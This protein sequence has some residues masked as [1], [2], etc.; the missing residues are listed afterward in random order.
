MNEAFIADERLAAVDRALPQGDRVFK[1]LRAETGADALFVSDETY[2]RYVASFLTEGG[3]ALV[4]ETGVKLFTDARYIEAA[5]KI[6]TPL[7]VCV[8]TLSKEN[9]PEAYLSRYKKVGVPF[10]EI[11][12][13]EFL[14]LQK[15]GAQFVDASAAIR[16]CA[17]VKTKEE[18]AMI[19][20]ACDF[21]EEGLLRSLPQIREG[22]SERDLAAVL[23]NEMRSLGADGTSFDTIVAF[24]AG[25]AV[26]HHE[27]DDTKLRYGDPVLIDFGCRVGGYCSD[28]TRTFLFGDDGKHEAFKKSYRCVLGAHKEALSRIQEGMTGG[29]ADAIARD[30]LS[31]CG[32]GGYFTHSLG[33]GIGLKVHEFPSLRPGNNEPLKNGMVFSDEPGVYIAGEFG[34]RIEDTVAMIDGKACTL[35][36]KVG[37]ELIVL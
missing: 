37:K 32:Y 4:D 30:Y 8:Q 10:S 16:S 36:K 33:H 9:A 35:M 25:A 12:H 27:T 7:G 2:K 14:S 5:K 21:A 17:C 1:A 19:R 29:E 22:M 3:Y 23:E 26:P 20:R 6:L 11:S 15:S 34:I 18:I 28:M 24:G 13:A 31:S